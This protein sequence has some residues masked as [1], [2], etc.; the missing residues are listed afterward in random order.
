[1]EGRYLIR[2]GK[3][4]MFRN[5]DNTGDVFRQECVVM[6]SLDTTGNKSVGYKFTI[7]FTT[8]NMDVYKT[9][10]AK[11][12][13]GLGKPSEEQMVADSE[14]PDDEQTLGPDLLDA[15]LDG[16]YEGRCFE[17]TFY[18]YTTDNGVHVTRITY[19]DEATFE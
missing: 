9:E 7:L 4:E 8:K 15:V 13:F 12:T 2:L 6:E 19:G 16:V 11:I 14:L 3:A 5:R 18:P 1:M 17:M 10:M